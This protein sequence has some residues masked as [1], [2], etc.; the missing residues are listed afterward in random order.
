MRYM[1]KHWQSLTPVSFLLLPLSW[2]YCLSVFTRRQLYHLKL[3]QAIRLPVPVIVVGNL[4]V[5]GTGKTPLVIWLAKLLTQA[6]FY[7]G[8]VGRGYGGNARTW[9][10]EIFPDSDPQQAGDESVLLARHC[11]CPVFA[12]PDRVRAAET[13]LA[14]YGCT[15]IISDDG[16]QHYRLARDIEIA[17][18][19][20]I[21]RFGNGRCLPAGPLRE[22][23][24]RLNAVHARVVNG[25]PAPGEWRLNLVETGFWNLCSPETRVSADYFHAGQVHAVAG[26]GHPQRFFN[27]LRAR[28]LQVIEHPFPDHYCFQPGDINF[29]PAAPVIMTEKDA[30]KC[31]RFAGPDYWYM[32]VAAQ[33][34][35]QFA[36]LILQLLR[37]KSHG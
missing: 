7:P 6:G 21:R 25:D 28:G 23:P 31:Q 33:P 36:E 9:P 32:A 16:L 4:T 5:G 12:G 15:V 29:S 8:V 30:V 19:D 10:L 11:Q 17:V 3:K 14:R 22:T 24:R 27:Q 34:D 20:G 13:L 37:E 26:I 1:E 18:I 2:V 35:P